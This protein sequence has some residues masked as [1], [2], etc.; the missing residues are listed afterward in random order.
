MMRVEKRKNGNR[1][2]AWDGVLKSPGRH[3]VADLGADFEG[4]MLGC[5]AGM[6]MTQV[7]RKQ[8]NGFADTIIEDDM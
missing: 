8:E 6:L 4:G 7:S 3:G 1:K 5:V 2:G